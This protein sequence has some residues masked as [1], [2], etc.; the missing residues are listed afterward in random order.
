MVSVSKET[1]DYLLDSGIELVVALPYINSNFT[2]IPIEGL[3]EVPGDLEIDR[4][5]HMTVGDEL[6][7]E[8][9]QFFNDNGLVLIVEGNDNC[10]DVLSI[11]NYIEAA[12]P[13]LKQVKLY[14][15]EPAY[16]ILVGSI[17]NK[18]SVA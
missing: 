2:I 18:P 16:T 4:H 9:I 1:D 7:E 3:Y 6:T 13:S 14:A 15:F 17:H 12:V 11:I 10:S 5:R 8:D